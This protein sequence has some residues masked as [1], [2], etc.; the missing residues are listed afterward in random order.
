MVSLMREA[1]SNLVAN[2]ITYTPAE[3][4]ITLFAAGDGAGWS[5][6]VEDNGPGLSDEER[7]TLGHRFQRGASASANKGGFGLGLAIARSIAQRHQGELQLVAREAG[8]GLHAIIWWP[9]L[10]AS[11][12]T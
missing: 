9:R 1:L 3:G 7:A 12:A 2:A 6:N 11:A 4:T 8:R 5:L 10:S